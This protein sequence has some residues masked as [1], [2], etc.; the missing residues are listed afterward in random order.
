MIWAL[1]AFGIEVHD[2]GKSLSRCFYWLAVLLADEFGVTTPILRNATVRCISKNMVVHWWFL[3]VLEID[4]GCT[5][6]IPG[7][8]STIC[9]QVELQTKMRWM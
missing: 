8:L 4:I 6:P 5:L 3:G 9:R 1:A 7:E 2:A